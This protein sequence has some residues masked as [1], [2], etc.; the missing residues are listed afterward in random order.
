[1]IQINTLFPHLQQNAV[2]LSALHKLSN[3]RTD[4]VKADKALKSLTS[5][6]CCDLYTDWAR[7]N[8]GIL[9]DG[10]R[11]CSGTSQAGELFGSNASW[12]NRNS[13]KT[14]AS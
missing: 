1:M 14:P 8:S 11:S 10:R 12:A 7:T 5:V 6:W 13:A 3:F 2:T 9:V 4:T